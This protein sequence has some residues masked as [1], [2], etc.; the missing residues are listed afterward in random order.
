MVANTMKPMVAV[1][2]AAD[3]VELMAVAVEVDDAVRLATAGVDGT[4]ELVVAVV[5]VDTVVPTAAGKLAGV[6]VK[7]QLEKDKQL[8]VAAAGVV[9]QMLV[10]LAAE[11][12]HN[13]GDCAAKK[14]SP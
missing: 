12:G 14:L 5:V 6:V 3:T 13:L 1:V 11:S 10:R 8:D 4:V 2:V 9:V 7:E